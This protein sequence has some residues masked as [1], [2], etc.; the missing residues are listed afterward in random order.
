MTSTELLDRP[1]VPTDVVLASLADIRRANTLFGGR[2]AVL[3]ALAPILRRAPR[4]ARWTLLDLGTGAGDIP[5]AAMRLATRLG[6]RLTAVGLERQ[7]AAATLAGRAGVYPIVAHLDALPLAPKSA[8]IV[9]MSQVL[10]HAS[11]SQ[12]A[13][14]VRLADRLAR[15]AVIVADLRRSPLAALGIWLASFPLGFHPVSRHDG[16]ISVRRGFTPGE[17]SDLLRAT[18]IVARAR[19]RPG[20]RVVAVWEPAT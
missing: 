15:R 12:A 2:R 20:F 10:H 18:G 7:R 6:V 8:D 14:W 5:A 9:L 3:E 1:D 4:R 13:K 19:P 16:V 11:R 17:L